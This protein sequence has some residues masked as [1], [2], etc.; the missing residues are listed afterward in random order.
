MR[1][2]KNIS[3]TFKGDKPTLSVCN[4]IAM[5]IQPPVLFLSLSSNFKPVAVPSRR[6]SSD[7]RQFIRSEAQQLLRE[8][9]IEQS[10]SP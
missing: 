7:D 6:Y 2:H 3:I 8:G 1:Q 4:L 9:I 5:S 10:D